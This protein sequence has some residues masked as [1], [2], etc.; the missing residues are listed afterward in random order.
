MISGFGGESMMWSL[1]SGVVFSGIPLE[2]P[3]DSEVLL[4]EDR[5]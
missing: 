4:V 5:V 3:T 2:R 1:W